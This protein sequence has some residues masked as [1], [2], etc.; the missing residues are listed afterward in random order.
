MYRF[1]KRKKAILAALLGLFCVGIIPAGCLAEEYD[2]SS[3]GICDEDEYVLILRENNHAE[4]FDSQGTYIG[5]CRQA[6]DRYQWAV[7]VKKDDLLCYSD[8]EKWSVFS[9]E[10]L[11]TVLE[12]P[13]DQYFLYDNGN[14][15]LATDYVNGNVSLYDHRGEWLYSMEAQVLTQDGGG[16]ARVMEMD[17]GYV[18]SV[19][20]VL[21]SDIAPVNPV[22]IRSDGKETRL[23]TDPYLVE[24]FQQ[25][26][27]SVFGQYLLIFD[28]DTGSHAVYS[29]DGELM[30]DQIESSVYPYT[31]DYSLYSWNWQPTL[32]TRRGTG[33][34]EVYDSKLQL[35]GTIPPEY[36]YPGYAS[37]FL[38]GMTY[39]ELGGN[40]CTGFAD[41]PDTEWVPCSR[42]ADGCLIY[43]Y[44]ELILIPLSA[45]E[46]LLS[47]ND[48]YM[49]IQSCDADENYED[50]LAN[51]RTGEKI[52][53]SVWEEGYSLYFSLGKNY[54]LIQKTYP[55]GVGSVQ[56]LNDQNEVSYAS[57]KAEG[58]AW[59]NGYVRLTRGIYRGIADTEGNWIVRTLA[60][61]SE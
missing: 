25:D 22:W 51:R 10:K 21:D 49:I 48:T 13:A 36:D 60:G 46:E 61:W 14:V 58:F 52:A 17:D 16:Y 34:L 56:I 7:T 4:I 38:A 40:I 44:G 50:Y 12:F 43:A 27:V 33:Y 26:L 6:L 32:V 47:L 9:M 31:R 1:N 8:E 57:D 59:K 2:T 24:M 23:I 3:P 5:N 11:E 39:E 42:T 37:G 28:R 45:S 55:E 18:I 29:L 54:S 35:L 53:K 41:Y 20:N 30:L 15:C 19:Y